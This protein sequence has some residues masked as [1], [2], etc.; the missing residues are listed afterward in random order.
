MEKIYNKLVRDN[1][2]EII[3][4]DKAEPRIRIL[5]QE[6]YLKELFRKLEEEAKETAEAGKNKKE[7]MKEIGDVYEIID[8]IIDNCGL[9]KEEII[10]LKNQRKTER[11]GFEKKIFLESVSN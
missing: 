11:G 4:R 6:E 10:K 3:R 7:L 9:D 2:P 1:I 5:E 8:A